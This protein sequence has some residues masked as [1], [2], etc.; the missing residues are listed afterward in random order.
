M[1][2]FLK[3]QSLGVITADTKNTGVT[4]ADVRK[5]LCKKPD[6]TVVEFTATLVPNTTK[7]TYTLQA[8]DLD[9]SGNY[10]L[11]AFFSKDGKTAYGE[12]FM[13]SISAPLK[14]VV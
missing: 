2:S 1:K 7:I 14:V 5:I 6:N 4:T 11:Q 9:Q 3:T 10:V 12:E 8:G 13:L